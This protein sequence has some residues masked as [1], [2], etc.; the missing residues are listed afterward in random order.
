MYSRIHLEEK[1]TI[2]GP[3]VRL[4]SLWPLL[5]RLTSLWWPVKQG[6]DSISLGAIIS[7]S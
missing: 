4:V 2:A 5:S 7:P 1:R 6:I 3:G